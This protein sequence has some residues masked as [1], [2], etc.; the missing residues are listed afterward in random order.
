MLHKTALTSVY[1]QA[2][3]QRDWLQTSRGRASVNLHT[4]RAGIG[5]EKVAGRRVEEG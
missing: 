5:M 2:Q 4:S 1:L 3:T